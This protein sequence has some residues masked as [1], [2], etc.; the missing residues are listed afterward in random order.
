MADDHK[1][2]SENVIPYI[3]ARADTGERR[4]TDH[5]YHTDFSV[6]AAD[7]AYALRA[8]AK[9][10]SNL[11][12]DWENVAE[13][14]EALGKSQERELA[15]RISTIL[16]HLIKLQ[17]SPAT[18]PDNGWR[19][20][21]RTQRMELAR[22]LKGE[23]TLRTTVP[24]VIQDELEGAKEQALDDLADHGEQPRV[25]VASLIYT[26]DQVLGRWFGD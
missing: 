6:W 14:I 7:Q 15:S 11:P 21:V 1:P 4:V 20:T 18:E 17:A 2:D 24:A 10:T 12:I 3:E 13:E 25:D 19:R 8:A 5:G 26:E 23:A 9:R 22:L 16:V